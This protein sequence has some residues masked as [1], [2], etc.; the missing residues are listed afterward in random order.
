M[1]GLQIFQHTQIK[2]HRTIP[3]INRDTFV[4]H[5]KRR[6]YCK[7]DIFFLFALSVYYKSKILHIEIF[8]KCF[9]LNLGFLSLL[10]W[11]GGGLLNKFE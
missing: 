6:I 1:G 10:G 3:I 9:L 2:T 11:G 5:L 4:L 8:H 7:S